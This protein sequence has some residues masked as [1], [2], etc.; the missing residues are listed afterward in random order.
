MTALTSRQLLV[1]RGIASY[2]EEYGYAPPMVE[3]GRRA[4]LSSTSTVHHHL[5]R[6]TRM[7]WLERAP[8][9]PG[10]LRVV[11]TPGV[12]TVPVLR[13]EPCGGDMPADHQ[14]NTGGS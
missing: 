5:R 14:C 7:G 11:L 13:C 6:L 8:R 2:C 3:I 12:V 9:R 1:L 10:A 4:G